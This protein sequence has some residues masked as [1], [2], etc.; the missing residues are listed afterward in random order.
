MTK[1][2]TIGLNRYVKK[3]DGL[4]IYELGSDVK[5]LTFPARRWVQLTS[6]V[7]QVDQSINLLVKQNVDRSEEYRL[8]P[9]SFA[10]T[11][12]RKAWVLRNMARLNEWIALKDVMQKLFVKYPILASTTPCTYEP[13]HQICLESAFNSTNCSFQRQ[14]NCIHTDRLAS[15]RLSW[16][17]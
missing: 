9:D 12:R 13:N 14:R 2:F 15:R 1:L 3:Q 6:L 17:A 5:S 4:T 11:T 16:C 10:S 8:Q 7:E